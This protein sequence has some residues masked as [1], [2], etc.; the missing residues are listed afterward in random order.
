[1]SILWSRVVERAKALAQLK[2]SVAVIV[3]FL[4]MAGGWRSVHEAK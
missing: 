3:G 2:V 4:R 1:V